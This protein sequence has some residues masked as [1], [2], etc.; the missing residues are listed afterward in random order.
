MKLLNEDQLTQIN[1]GKIPKKVIDFVRDQIIDHG[2]N[3]VLAHKGEIW[4]SFKKGPG[5][6][7]PMRQT[8]FYKVFSGGGHAF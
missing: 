1:G 7:D 5:R 8:D 4:Q 2:I 6:N 3:W